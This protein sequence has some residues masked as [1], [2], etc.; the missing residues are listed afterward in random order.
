MPCRFKDGV[1]NDCYTHWRHFLVRFGRF[2]LVYVISNTLG[3]ILRK[4]TALLTVHQDQNHLRTSGHKFRYL[5]KKERLFLVMSAS[6][7]LLRGIESVLLTAVI[8]YTLSNKHT[9][10]LNAKVYATS[11]LRSM[12]LPLLKLK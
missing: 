1:G 10:K 3:S 6:W 5:K 4:I 7:Y 8:P 2:F 9:L 12:N 11:N